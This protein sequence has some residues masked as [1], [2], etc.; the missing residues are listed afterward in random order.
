[1]DPELQ[2]LLGRRFRKTEG[3]TVDGVPSVYEGGGGASAAT[4]KNGAVS[5]P[6]TA[7]LQTFP[8]YRTSN[9][10]WVPL[11][12]TAEKGAPAARD[13]VWRK[14]VQTLT[15]RNQELTQEVQRQKEKV[16]KGWGSRCEPE[17][18]EER[19]AVLAKT[20]ELLYET[21][22]TVEENEHWIQERRD[23]CYALVDRR[24]LTE[25]MPILAAAANLAELRE[26][27]ETLKQK[28]GAQKSQEEKM[29]QSEAKRAAELQSLRA[30]LEGSQQ[31]NASLKAK[32]DE[33]P[34]LLQAKQ[35]EA[36]TAVEQLKAE[37]QEL[38]EQ[39]VASS[40]M[41][42]A[43]SESRLRTVMTSQ[44]ASSQQMKSAIQSVEALIV[45]A[46]RELDSKLLRERRAA[47]ENL[48]HA[49]EKDQED[50]LEEA[51]LEAKRV[52]V[53]PE[54]IS[55]AEGKLAELKAMTPE[56]K[57]AKAARELEAARKKEAYVVIKKDDPEI[58]AEY[59]ADLGPDVKWMEWKDFRGRTLLKFAQDC[60]CD[61]IVDYLQ[62]LQPRRE[63]NPWQH[64]HTV[65]FHWERDHHVEEAGTSFSRQSSGH[66]S[67]ASAQPCVARTSSEGPEEED[68]SGAEVVFN[69]TAEA[70]AEVMSARRSIEPRSAGTR[71]QV[72][73][74]YKHVAMEDWSPAPGEEEQ[75]KTKAY[76]AVVQDDSEAL[77][78]VIEE[79][80][81]EVWSQWLNKAGKDLLT[82]TQERGRPLA[83]SILATAL[84][85]IE[86][87][88]KEAFEERES[89]WI[90]LAGE[91]MP[92]RA[93]VLEETPE[94]A[95][96]VLI[97][98]WDGE[99]EPVRMEKIFVRKMWS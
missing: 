79:V 5:A 71:Q 10:A 65:H 34:K 21:N 89:V 3:S 25:G 41:T 6:P 82:L 15:V 67:V 32:L 76:R 97:E 63:S 99:D 11:V 16:L 19:N 29:R 92:K 18:H 30:Q 83:Y 98:Y 86:E 88:K 74:A 62:S 95:E 31:E 73:G 8:K 38:R 22:K 68:A 72:V 52:E 81:S 42:A 46:R 35:D 28:L 40:G 84:G 93:T 66:A 50:Q 57:A 85:M 9:G 96:D 75:L 47:L 12:T 14:H 91:V 78:E 36:R 7:R 87:L 55:K 23:Q 49:M 44:G 60:R 69:L 53:S 56:Q 26:E 13:D 70:Q 24:K 77:V 43:C 2:A 48:H 51:I 17:A 39:L 90:F 33:V 27:N 54:D 64:S 37:C 80:P 45:E 94:E 59:V 58:L 4:A 61:R 1:M 20:Q